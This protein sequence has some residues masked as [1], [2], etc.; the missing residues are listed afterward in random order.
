MLCSQ[1]PGLPEKAL[2]EC[3]AV[4]R[5]CSRHH[6]SQLSAG[7][8]VDGFIISDSSINYNQIF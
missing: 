5:N 7:C 1:Y 3:H 2:R 8:F 6:S 4:H